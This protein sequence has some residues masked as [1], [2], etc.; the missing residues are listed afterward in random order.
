MDSSLIV[1]IKYAQHR[2]FPLELHSTKKPPYAITATD[3]LPRGGSREHCYICSRRWRQRQT[4]NQPQYKEGSFAK[5]FANVMD[6]YQ[7]HTPQN[8]DLT[9]EAFIFS[10]YIKLNCQKF[11]RITSNFRRVTWPARRLAALERGLLIESTGDSR[12]G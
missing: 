10:S 4:T 8:A 5:Y 6:F 9:F 11:K 2:C 7:C 12:T 1:I 3:G